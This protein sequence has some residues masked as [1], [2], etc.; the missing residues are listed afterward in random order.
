MSESTN[1]LAE[2][3]T[4]DQQELK[5][6]LE[7]KNQEDMLT[8]DNLVSESSQRKAE[9]EIKEAK[10]KELAK[11]KDELSRVS[12]EAKISKSKSAVFRCCRNPKLQLKVARDKIAKFYNGY[13]VTDD[14]QK[15]RGIISYVS[16]K[17]QR[18]VEILHIG[19]EVKKQLKI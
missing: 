15:I 18:K 9:E 2:S 8:F 11:T 12:M 17:N 10:E 19:N 14:I 7:A 13:C 5:N 4:Q 3:L 6:K 16:E 1:I